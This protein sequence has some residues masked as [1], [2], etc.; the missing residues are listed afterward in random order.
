L[1]DLPEIIRPVTDQ[2]QSSHAR[3][4]QT[5][6]EARGIAKDAAEEQFL[7]AHLGEYQGKVTEM[8]KNLDMNRSYLQTLM[9][10]HGMKAGDFKNV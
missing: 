10:K 3:A 8:A 6:E 5:I 2:H 9:K 1:Q 7:R 4:R